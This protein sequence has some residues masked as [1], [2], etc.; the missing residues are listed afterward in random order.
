MAN[1]SALIVVALLAYCSVAKV[2]HWT[3][4]TN[5]ILGCKQQPSSRHMH[6]S[7]TAAHNS[8]YSQITR[9]VC[10][11]PTATITCSACYPSV[12]AT[13]ATS[14]VELPCICPLSAT[15]VFSAQALHASSALLARLLLLLCCA[16]GPGGC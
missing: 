12:L 7:T 8:N 2:Q 6:S 11:Y 1:L 13:T 5:S 9:R 3:F 4:K 16:A 15:L 10:D 14:M